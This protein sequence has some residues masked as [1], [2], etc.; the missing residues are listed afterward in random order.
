MKFLKVLELFNIIH[1]NLKKRL[2]PILE[3]EGLSYTDFSVLIKIYKKNRCRPIELS[4]HMGIPAS[5]FTGILDRLE[6]RQFIRRL[7]DPN[8][9]RSIIIEKTPLLEA[10]VTK[11]LDA[12]EDELKKIFKDMPDDKK[13][14][15]Q[16]DFEYLSSYI[17]SK[18]KHERDDEA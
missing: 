7:S 3:R 6:E 15:L 18:S 9:R 17:N 13:K 10:V 11:L 16:E 5:T 4:E 14:R 8:D 2:R 12:V 1:K